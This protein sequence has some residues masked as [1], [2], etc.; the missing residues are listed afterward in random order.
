MCVLLDDDDALSRKSGKES[1]CSSLFHRCMLWCADVCR[2]S[3]SLF[4]KFVSNSIETKGPVGCDDVR[5]LQIHTHG[6]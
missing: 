5:D 4:I 1:P 3:R 2:V 6:Y